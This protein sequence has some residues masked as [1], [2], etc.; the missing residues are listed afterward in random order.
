MIYL[1]AE[2]IKNKK[3]GGAH[4]REEL[5]ALV[6]GYTGGHIPD[7]QMSAWL[8]A[9]CFQGLTHQE[10]AWLTEEMV[11]SGRRLNFSG[12]QKIAVD[13]HSTGGV[14][15]K[16]SL[17]LAPL[18]AAAGVAVPMM[19][20]RGL[21]HTGGTLDKLESIPGFN[22]RLTLGEF[23]RQVERLGVAIMGQTEEICP[24]DLKLYALRDV[25]ATVDS[26]P[27]ICA[28]I[29]SKKIAE[30]IGGLVLDVKFGSGA[31]MKTLADA[32]SLAV[33]LQRI[34]ELN[35]LKVSYLLTNMDQPLGAYIGN[36]VEVI[37]SVGILRGA[38]HI[39]NGVDLW[40]DVR[41]LTLELAAQMIHLASPSET[42]DKSK[43]RAKNLLECGAAY[44]MFQRLCAAQGAQSGWELT[45]PKSQGHV[46]SP[47]QGFVESFNTERIGLAA[48]A[49]GAG[50]AR[51]EDQIDPL[52]GIELL[53]KV[54][55]KVER[56]QPLFRLLG[57]KAYDREISEALIA[58]VKIGPQP[59]PHPQLIAK[60]SLA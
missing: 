49:M 15:D 9:V 40:T 27:L 14:G 26:I 51:S 38:S 59:G 6:S 3:Q 22:V 24:A 4:S 58:S 5:A 60:R 30:G 8:M 2:L 33:E 53:C 17:I 34:G 21:G 13:K 52:A 41:E 12:L 32:E 36:A 42:V 19:A 28:S 1:P 57:R 54:G 25:T 7:Y 10:T 39:V 45:M 23:Q 44:E 11:Y 50:R 37:E 35:G 18:V 20:G 56:G 29:M 47:S 55:D 46:L 48:V 16:V 31:F 43:D